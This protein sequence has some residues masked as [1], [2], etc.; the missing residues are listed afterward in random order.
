MIKSMRFECGRHVER[1]GRSKKIYRV[2]G[3]K[4]R[5]EETSRRVKTWVGG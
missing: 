1:M 2:L 5:R 3:E 4:A